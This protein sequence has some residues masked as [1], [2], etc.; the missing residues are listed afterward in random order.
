M[1]RITLIMSYRQYDDLR[2]TMNYGRSVAQLVSIGLQFASTGVQF[3]PSTDY[4]IDYS[5][6][7][8]NLEN[9]LQSLKSKKII[10]DSQL[11]EIISQFLLLE[12]R[13]VELTNR[14]GQTVVVC[15]GEL[16]FGANLNEAIA[17]ARKRFGNDL[18][19]YYSETIDIV[20]Y[21]TIFD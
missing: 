4:I 17:E 6:R 21:P 1:L 13:R 8:S 20:D 19:A 15:N 16:F 14:T 11:R 3:P 7:F 18:P 5:E 2:Y 10:N 9:H 12:N